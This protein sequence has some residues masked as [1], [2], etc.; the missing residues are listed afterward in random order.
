MKVHALWAVAVVTALGCASTRRQEPA[1]KP[2]SAVPDAAANDNGSVALE[3]A[4]DPELRAD[5]LGSVIAHQ[6][7]S[8]GVAAPIALVWGDIGAIPEGAKRV[9]VRSGSAKLDGWLVPSAH[10]VDMGRLASDVHD[11]V[12]VHCGRKNLWASRLSEPERVR[13]DFEHE[14]DENGLHPSRQT[15]ALVTAD[16]GDVSERAVSENIV[17]LLD[18]LPTRT[19]YAVMGLPE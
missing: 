14:S 9:R 10:Q 16:P 5:R 3:V 11:V 1:P 7:R 4:L 15:F 12:L 18:R 17:A 2:A 13:I 6:A 19:R 8:A